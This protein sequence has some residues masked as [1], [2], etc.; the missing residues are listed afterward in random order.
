MEPD[1]SLKGVG[2]IYRILNLVNGKCYIGRTICFYRRCHHYI[3]D[4]KN[5]RSKQINEYLLRSM[6]K[7]GLH[8][9]K[10]EVLEFCAA[11]IMGE[12]EIYWMDYHH[13]CN[14]EFGY[15]LR[16]DSSGGMEVSD[17]TREKISKR[18]IKEWKSGIRDSHSEKLKKSWES[19]DKAAQGEFFRKVLT[20][21]KYLVYYSE[22]VATE[23][24]YRDLKTAGLKSVISTFHKK[25]TNDVTFKGLRIR[26]VMVDED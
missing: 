22:N 6:T 13:S 24:Y 18:L 2:G 3:Y 12:R 1:I 7:H 9:F 15:N 23:M 10:Y 8:N 11:D 20:K 16:R 4:F 17:E 25:K 19:R 5:Q 26:R 14:R 21:Y